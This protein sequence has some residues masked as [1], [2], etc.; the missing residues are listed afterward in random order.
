M[1]EWD[2]TKRLKNLEKHKLDFMDAPL[3]FDG[4]PAVHASSP[5]DGETRFVS[6]AMIGE[7][8]YAVVWT[9]RSGNRRIISFRRARHGEENAYKTIYG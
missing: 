7:K 2:E 5:K 9:F 3:V 8:F 4:R 6:V 1:V